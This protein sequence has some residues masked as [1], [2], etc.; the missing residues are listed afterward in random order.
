MTGEL[1]ESYLCQ[2]DAFLC[3][4]KRR[5]ERF[6]GVGGEVLGGRVLISVRLNV[7]KRFKKINESQPWSKQ[8]KPF[9]FFNVGFQTIRDDGKPIKPL[10]P[11]S[12][13]PQKIVYEPFLDYNT[14]EIKQGA[15]FFKSLNMTILQYADHPEYKYEG[16][17]GQMERRHIHADSVVLVGKEANNIDDQALDIGQAQVFVKK[18]EIMDKILQLDAEMGR[19]VGIP[20]RGTLKRIQDRIRESGDINLNARFMRGVADKLG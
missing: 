4:A 6:W 5:K 12:K 7:L 13:D 20:Y 11:F 15:E 1:G 9:N 2:K 19:K 3:A 16:D 10:A 14:G 8:I 17:I 18:Q